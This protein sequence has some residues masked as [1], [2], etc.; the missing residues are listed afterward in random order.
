MNTTDSMENYH[1]INQIGE[2][3]FGRVYKGRRKYTGRLVAIKMINK[4]GQSKDD[5]VSFR[6]EIDL[7]QKVSHPNVMKMLSVFET[8]TDFCVVSEL[9]RGD[10]FQVIDDN[11]TLPEPVLK[12]VAA[13][14]VSS[15][16]HLHSLHIIHRDMKPQNIL[17]AENASLKICDFGFARALSNTTLVLT[18]IK[19]TPLYMAPELVQEQPYDE[20]VDIWALGVILY[21]LY[22]GKP[23]FFTN[24]IYKLIQMIVNSPIVFPG[25]ISAQFKD[26]LLEMLQKDP[27]KRTSCEELMK[28]PF[29]ADV[30]LSCFDDRVYKFK[31]EQFERAIK[32]SLCGGPQQTF[33]PKK[34]KIPDYQMIFVNPSA[35]SEEELL[36]AVKFLRKKN[37]P[38]DSPLAASFSFHFKEFI[39]KP[40][41]LDEALHVA[42]DLLRKDI[43]RYSVPFAIGVSLLGADMPLAS[44]DFFT[45]LLSVPFA[46]NV[47][48]NNDFQLGDMQ[49]DKTK[50]EKLRDRLL[51]FIFQENDQKFIGQTYSIFSFFVQESELFLSTVTGSFSPQLVP[52]LTSA[53]VKNNSD[54]IKTAA[55]CILSK[56]IEYDNVAITY[57]QPFKNFLEAFHNI[58]MK[59]IRSLSEH[60]LFSAAVSF[61]AVCLN[62]LSEIPEFQAQ[63]DVRSSL[64]T[65]P[66]FVMMMF[67]GK[68]NLNDRL[69]SLIKYGS[70]PPQ[71]QEDFLLIMSVLSSPFCH[72][73]VNVTH[74]DL[75][76]EN[77]S[78]LVPFHQPALLATLFA[79]DPNKV[80]QYL[81]MMVCLYPI[82]QCASTLSDYILHCLAKQ[83]NSSQNLVLA[84]C[85]AGIL[86]MIA[87][88]ISD[89]GPSVPANV[90]IVL[91]QIIMTFDRPNDILIEQATEILNSIFSIDSAAESGLI[92][93]SHLAR[94]SKDFLPALSECG[95]LNLAERALQ[96]EVPQIRAR[97]LDFIGNVCRHTALPDDYLGAFVPLLMD[98][99]RENNV[100]C[101]KMA[102]YALGNM[103]VYCPEIADPIAN[104]IGAVRHLLESND[105]KVVENGSGV[106][107][108]M[109]RK[110]GKLVKKLI[111]EG[112]LEA[113]LRTVSIEE[114]QGKTVLHLASFCQYDEGR[115]FLKLKKAQTLISKYT[116]SKNERI[117]RYAKNIIAAIS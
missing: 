35:H 27:S 36:L 5:I 111:G 110:S 93:A 44:I 52:I 11:Q 94:L 107:G 101:Q 108:N 115:A 47:V 22:Y 16:A 67:K 106:L 105:P 59:Q 82:P 38:P 34:S 102:A 23:P 97:A 79:L 33:K 30:N 19:G 69:E 62:Q 116:N 8:D 89:L 55:F 83:D 42:A 4:L 28:H 112:A 53:I 72:A 80:V 60:S 3:S 32:V 88:V 84:L 58:V 49:L 95:A 57:I 86:T 12:N 81:P 85:E 103:L 61:I 68:T 10:L 100:D 70:I 37:V 73:P 41:V 48:Q 51:M 20:K 31:S 114:L 96:A 66:N 117:Q 77:I 113:L 71:H 74:L 63:Y 109:V 92:I 2:G 99:I 54:L 18:S 25:D 104:D 17:I 45:E 9:A 91:A 13:Q 24:S 6:R 7:L 1:L 90:V 76:V 87:S 64:S 65:L 98:N 21:E 29:I 39:S 75:C 78:G 46:M 26:F 15:L 40:S 43:E 14:L 56:V 50:C